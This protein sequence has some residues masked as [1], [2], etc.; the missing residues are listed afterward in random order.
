[1]KPEWMENQ[2]CFYKENIRTLLDE[3]QRQ[4][5]VTIEL[6]AKDTN[7]LFTGKLPAKDLG[8]CIANY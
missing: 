4:Y 3:V 5:N 1:M 2:M 7:S 8:C 6:N